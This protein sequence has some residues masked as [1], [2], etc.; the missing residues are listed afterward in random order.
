LF[1][2]IDREGRESIAV[3]R[4]QARAE[5]P[6]R[7]AQLAEYAARTGAPDAEAITDRAGRIID[8]ARLSNAAEQYVYTQLPV[9]ISGERRAAELYVFKRKRAAISKDDANILLSL[10]LPALGHWEALV[11]VRGHDVS[12]QMRAASDGAREHLSGSTARLHDILSE[13]GYRLT[14]ARVTSGGDGAAAETTPLTACAALT[15]GREGAGIDV[16]V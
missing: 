10:D 13:A 16:V 3:R 4:R 15:R 8:Q 1:T 14:G 5:L 6:A 11:N 9:V 12:L 7:A 2:E